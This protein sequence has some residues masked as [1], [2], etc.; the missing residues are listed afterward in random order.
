MVNAPV[1]A[2]QRVCDTPAV[3][4]TPTASHDGANPWTA[5]AARPRVAPLAIA[6]A[7]R[8]ASPPAV[9]TPSAIL[10]KDQPMKRAL[11]VPALLT[12]ASAAGAADAA[13]DRGAG[14]TLAN[15]TPREQMRELASDRPTTTQNPYSIDAGHYQVEIEALSWGRDQVGRRTTTTTSAAATVKAGLSDVVDVE[16]IIEPFINRRAHDGSIGLN[17][18]VTGVGD[19]TARLKWNLWGDNGGQTA[20][21]LMPFITLPTHSKKLDPDR[22]VTG[23]LIAPLAADLGDGWRLGLMLELDAVRNAQNNGYVAQ[24]VQ[25]LVV[26]HAIV[27]DLRGFAE[28]VNIT[29]AE[30]QTP[31]Q[32]YLGA[33]ATF[34]FTPDVQFDAGVDLGLTSAS[35]D[36]RLSV[37]I[38][39]R[40]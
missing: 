12:A 20:F 14:H 38:D 30:R 1:A 21:A 19:F 4:T 32:T 17:D 3:P 36:V 33:G 9:R 29:N 28:M 11:L 37:G 25:S 15:P 5:R 34:A 7:P 6:P 16:A 10:P 39:V 26:G 18:T 35:E 22:E 13:A 27:G 23:G 40:R 31:G 24:W 2:A 8:R